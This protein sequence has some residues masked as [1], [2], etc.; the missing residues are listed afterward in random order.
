MVVDLNVLPQWL[1]IS[2]QRVLLAF[3]ENRT[4]KG[5]HKQ[6]CSPIQKSTNEK[7]PHHSFTTSRKQNHSFIFYQMYQP[8]LLTQ[9]I[10]HNIL[11][12]IYLYI[13][14][15]ANKYQSCYQKNI[16][17]AANKHLPKERFT[18][19]DDIGSQKTSSR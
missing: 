2:F 9:D 13:I 5:R 15:Y 10:I 3:A 14:T 11:S 4:E 7:I 19:A 18:L 8:V 1:Q 17:I 12:F 16:D 6:R